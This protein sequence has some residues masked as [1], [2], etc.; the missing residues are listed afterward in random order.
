MSAA[1]P[2]EWFEGWPPLKNTCMQLGTEPYNVRTAQIIPECQEAH[3]AG[4]SAQFFWGKGGREDLTSSTSL[5]CPA[6]PGSGVTAFP[7]TP[8]QIYLVVLRDSTMG[9]H[10]ASLG[11]ADVHQKNVWGPRLMVREGF[12]RGSTL[13]TEPLKQPKFPRSAITSLAGSGSNGSGTPVSPS[14]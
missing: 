6:R 14:R 1:L 10:A 5:K 9:V 2:S 12:D 7:P 3:N 8:S 4:V 13:T 11:A